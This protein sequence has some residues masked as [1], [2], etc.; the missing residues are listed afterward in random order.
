MADISVISPD[1]GTTELN[2]KDATARTNIGDLSALTTTAKTNLVAAVNE[3][4]A[5]GGGGGTTDYTALSNK[6]QIN[7]IT[8][9]GNKSFS[10]LGL[11]TVASTGAYSDLSGTPT[12]DQT[13]GASSTNAQ[14]GTAVA[15][16]ISGKADSSAL[17]DWT[18]TATVDANSQVTFTGLNDNYGYEL[19]CADKLVGIEEVEK[20]GS[21]TS[22]Q[23]VY[24]LTDAEQGDTC[25]LRI[26]R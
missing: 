18:S 26:V 8:L 3:V 7:S 11:A 12:V 1:G 17:D 24:T 21:G 25:K 14:S 23:M 10:D 5:G 2:I 9:T 20:T 13:Y 22:V 15:S 6:P 19:F 16:A 4:A